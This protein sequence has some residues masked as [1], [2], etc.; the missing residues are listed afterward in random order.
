MAKIPIE[1]QTIKPADQIIDILNGNSKIY[2]QNPYASPECITRISQ[3][4]YFKIN[5]NNY[6][7]M[8]LDLPSIYI[9]YSENTWTKDFL[10][11]YGS[12]DNKINYRILPPYNDKKLIPEKFDKSNQKL[13]INLGA[14]TDE[15]KQIVIL[16]WQICQ[17]Y[18]FAIYSKILGINTLEYQTDKEYISAVISA[19]ETEETA[20]IQEYLNNISNKNVD[21][22]I[23]NTIRSNEEDETDDDDEINCFDFGLITKEAFTEYIKRNVKTLDKKNPCLSYFYKAKQVKEIRIKQRFQI[24]K[25]NIKDDKTGILKPVETVGF[26]GK[27]VVLYNQ[28]AQSK[29]MKFITLCSNPTIKKKIHQMTIKDFQFKDKI[30]FSGMLVLSLKP[31]C[32]IY[33]A[34][35]GVRAE[36]MEWTITQ[37]SMSKNTISQQD[38]QLFI[39]EENEDSI[40]TEDSE[41]QNDALE[42]DLI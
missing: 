42:N 9:N 29:M 36:T 1:I 39:T 25:F 16:E 41:I 6:V 27:F 37:I 32:N 24:S 19:L 33:K 7:D 35:S 21:I 20:A 40:D 11:I 31:I 4:N 14:V 2:I 26:T 18:E 10:L 28:E 8:T 12:N 15:K 34:S 3:D 30:R 23:A 13:F 17:A 22:K 38:Q 5:K